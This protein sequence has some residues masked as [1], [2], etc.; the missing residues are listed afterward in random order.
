MPISISPLSGGPEPST[1]LV[2]HSGAQIAV[3]HRNGTMVVR[4]SAGLPSQSRRLE[5]Q[6]RKQARF[7]AAG[8]PT[9]QVTADGK[10]CGLYFF[11]MEYVTATS[12]AQC[13]AQG[14]TGPTGA[15]VLWLR[16]W[17]TRM[18]GSVRGVIDPAACVAKV[19]HVIAHVHEA[20]GLRFHPHIA[21]IAA[22]LEG[23]SWPIMPLSDCHGDLTTENILVGR[24]GHLILIDFDCSDLSSFYMDVA[25]LYQDLMGLWCIR[26]L[27]IS[28]PNSVHLRNSW[29]AMLRMKKGVDDLIEN[30]LPDL[31]RYIPSLVCLNL[32]RALPYCTDEAVGN[33]IIQRI[34][35]L[36]PF[37]PR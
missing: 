3:L 4:K 15:L 28:Q 13:I 35:A 20:H 5:R 24:D 17:I 19:N 26:H 32:L 2:G 30:A 31:L 29:L 34:E 27:A 33:F 7:Y 36:L 12:I 1:I 25:K 8:I 11:E 22:A 23:L 18:Q 6:Q 16:D 14:D 10:E 9:P 21:Y 37:C